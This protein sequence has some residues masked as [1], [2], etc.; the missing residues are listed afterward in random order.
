MM[1]PSTSS[2]IWR[3]FLSDQATDTDAKRIVFLGAGNMARSLIG[4]LLQQGFAPNNLAACDPIAESLSAIEVLGPVR[5]STSNEALLADADVVVLA[6]KPQIM[7][8]ALT[9]LAALI[10]QRLQPPQAQEEPEV[11]APMAP[12]ESPHHDTPFPPV[13]RSP[14]PEGAQ[15]QAQLR[16][17][18]VNFDHIRQRYTE[19]ALQEVLA[20]YQQLLEC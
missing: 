11:P 3:F 1:A 6:V 18:I 12:P 20:E 10:Q 19:D 9:P 7:K 14:V 16:L 2:A 13:A 8:Q 15:L 17:S 4:G 5:T